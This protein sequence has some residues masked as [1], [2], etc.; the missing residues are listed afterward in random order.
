MCPKDAD[1]MANNVDPVQT[2]PKSSLIWVYTVCTDLSVWKLGIITVYFSDIE[3]FEN[4][5]ESYPSAEKIE[6]LIERLGFLPMTVG[7][8]QK[9]RETFGN[10]ECE[11]CGRL[12][13]SKVDYEP[14][15]RTHTGRY[16]EKERKNWDTP[17]K[18]L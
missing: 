8:F 4:E 15:V 17:K 16:Q 1:R 9:M 2:A 6:E 14:H 5:E 11:F 3:Q 13:F 18:F 7:I 12:F 10:E